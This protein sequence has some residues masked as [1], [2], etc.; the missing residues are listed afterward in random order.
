MNIEYVGKHVHLGDR[1]KNHTEEKLNKLVPF[2]QE[3]VEVRVILETEKNRQ[4]AD[5]HLTHRFGAL[6]AREETENFLDSVNGAVEKLTKQARRSR[7]K[8]IDKRRRADR[9][10]HEEI[11]WPMEVLERESLSSG[12]KPAVIKST[13]LPI[14]PMTIDEAA[15]VLEGSKNDF[16]VFR[17]ST[18]SEVSV[19]YKRKDD[20]YGLI[21]PES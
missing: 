17:D 19:L 9:S 20:N 15:L 6:Q 7:K 1:L 14:K 13:H 4:I 10:V 5:V 2:V 21:V 11:R 8:F 12:T 18:S 16:V 3:P